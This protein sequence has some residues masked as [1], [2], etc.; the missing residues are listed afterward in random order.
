MLC[1]YGDTN[2]LRISLL[3]HLSLLVCLTVNTFLLDPQLL[4]VTTS[5]KCINDLPYTTCPTLYSSDSL[6]V[7]ATICSLSMSQTF[8]DHF[9]QNFT[10]DGQT[11]FT[12]LWQF[13]DMLTLQQR[14][15]VAAAS[16]VSVQWTV[17]DLTGAY[18]SIYT[19]SGIWRF[20]SAWVETT[21]WSAL[22]IHFSN[23]GGVWGAV[24]GILDSA[25]PGNDL[26]SYGGSWGQQ[27]TVVNPIANSTES[28]NCAVYYVNGTQ[29]TSANIVNYVFVGQ[30]RDPFQGMND[31]HSM[32]TL[33]VCV[34]NTKGFIIFF[35][36]IHT[37]ANTYTHTHTHTHTHTL[38]KDII[39]YTYMSSFMIFTRY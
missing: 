38:Y 31:R 2:R 3:V 13:V 19:F 39:T 17:T 26:S 5:T 34:G 1:V 20:S 12:I 27:N 30:S 6:P 10:V 15:G 35:T 24:N 16:G 8:H 36:F 18:P 4:A 37:R 14:F 25:V 23:G 28:S 32:T 22:G 9:W 11:L 29:F 33:T 7:L 21:Q